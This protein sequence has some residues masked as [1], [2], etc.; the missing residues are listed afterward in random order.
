[1]VVV[2]RAKSWVD[3]DDFTVAEDRSDEITKELHHVKEELEGELKNLKAEAKKVGSIYARKL[4]FHFVG[5]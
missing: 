5:C 4:D 1:M 3:S 2:K